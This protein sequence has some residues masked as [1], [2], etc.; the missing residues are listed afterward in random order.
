MRS[1]FICIACLAV[2]LVKAQTKRTLAEGSGPVLVMLHGGTFDYHGFAP[3]SKLLADSFRVIRMLQFNVQYANDGR[4]LPKN[5]S[6]ALESRAIGATLD[7]MQIDS[8]IILVGHSYGG[9]LAFDYALRHPQRIRALVLIE[10]PLFDLAKKKGRYSAKMKEIDSLS[11]GFKPDADITE[12][13]I[14]AFRCKMTGCDS[15]DIRQH[16]MWPKWLAQKDRLRGLS[17]V[18]QYKVDIK[19]IQRFHKPVLIITGSN[20][21]EP[22][23]TVDE[24]LAEV[25]PQAEKASLPGDHIAVYQKVE[26][27]ISILKNFLQTSR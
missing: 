21:I 18:S 15:V 26:E 14:R 22:N 7:S 17:V 9:L 24:L 5:Y 20:T 23:Q 3:H 12:E 10:P 19:S 27:F 2:V 11:R 4:P 1:L 13:M 16:P 25:F 6:V 8:P